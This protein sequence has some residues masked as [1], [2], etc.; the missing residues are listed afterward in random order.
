MLAGIK[1]F[2]QN[3]KVRTWL[4][5][6]FTLLFYYTRTRPP[7][8]IYDIQTVGN[9]GFLAVGKTGVVV[10][11]LKDPGNLIEV[12]SL[13]TFGDAYSLQV[14]GAFVFVADG[15][16]G[17][18]MLSTNKEGLELK[19][20]YRTPGDALD[21]AVSG[22]NA[23]AIDSKEDLL[24]LEV[25]EREGSFF[26]TSNHDVPDKAEKIKIL[27]N[28]AYISNNKNRF[29]IYDISVPNN[30]I[31]L[32]HIDLQA[33]IENFIVI[34][35]YAYLAA[36]DMGLVILDVSQGVEITIAGQYNQIKQAN[37][38]D[39]RGMYAYVAS[40]GEGY[41]VLDISNF[42]RITEVGRESSLSDAQLIR[43]VDDYACV[44]DD[45]IGLKS[46]Y[47]PVLFKFREQEFAKAQGLYE[48]V[49]VKGD[50]AYIAAGNSGLKVIEI[51][52][53]NTPLSGSYIDNTGDYATSLDSQGDYI[54][55]TY[56]QKGLHLYNIGEDPRSPT[57]EGV[58]S[59]VPGEPQD[60][61]VEGKLVFVASGS[62]GLQIIDLSDIAS[63][64]IYSLDTPG[65]AKGVFVLGD[66]AYIADG[67]NGLQI[68]A[69]T[70]PKNPSIIQNLNTF[71]DA[72]SVYVAKIKNSSE[73]ERTY[74][75]IANGNAGLF[76]A[77]ITD[78]NHPVNVATYT[79]Q[80]SAND[81]IVRD[82]TVYLLAEKNGLVLLDIS[83]IDNP[84]EL[85]N[86][87]TPGKAKRVD[88]GEDEI[89]YIAD[90]D[91][92]L[93]IISVFDPNEP[94]EIGFF[95]IPVTARV[96]LV[97]QNQGFMVDGQVGMWS[98][99]MTEPQA[100]SI[101][102]LF[103]TPGEARNLALDG[104][105]AY[106]AD[107][108]SGLQVV[109]VSNSLNPQLDGSYTKI[110]NA[111]AVAVRGGYA[112]V[113]TGERRHLHILDIENLSDIK[114]IGVFETAGE[115]LNIAIYESYAYIV[116]GTN[117][118]EVVNIQDPTDPSLTSI[119]KEFY[120]QDARSILFLYNHA[121]FVDGPGGMKVYSV[122]SPAKPEFVY[123]FPVLGGYATSITVAGEYVFLAVDRKGIFP[124]D[125]LDLNNIMYVGTLELNDQEEIQGDDEF[126]ALSI[127]VLSDPTQGSTQFINYTTSNELGLQIFRAEGNAF[128][129]QVGMYET[130]GE[131]SLGQVLGAMPRVVAGIM[132]GNPEVV[133][134][135]IWARLWYMAFGTGIFVGLFCLYLVLFSQFVLPVQTLREGAK[136]ITRLYSSLM[137][138]HGPVVFIKEG[139]I[140]A[141]PDELDRRGPGV[142]R[143]DLNSAIVL[144]KRALLQPQY[145]QRYNRYVRR[146][147]RAGQK[148]PRAR[149][150]GPGVHF[151]EPYENIHGIADLRPQFRIR[152]G[153][154]A[155][156]RDG[157]EIS[158]PV[159]ILFSLGQPPET[160]DV[161]YDGER[162]AE[163]LRVI[164]MGEKNIPLREK[165]QVLNEEE[166][167]YYQRYQTTRRFFQ[168][169]KEIFFKFTNVEVELNSENRNTINE[170]TYQAEKLAD[171]LLVMEVFEVRQFLGELK[172][173]CS[174]LNEISYQSVSEL[175]GEANHLADQKL[176]E[177][178]TDFYDNVYQLK[179]Q[180]GKFIMQLT[181][182]I[183]PDDR[184]EIHRYVQ[185]QAEIRYFENIITLVSNVDNN[186]TE[187]DDV[188]LLTHK[189]CQLA[190]RWGIHNRESIQ[191][192]TDCVSALVLEIDSFN[193]VE[194]Q[195][196]IYHIGMLANELAH[197][198]MN[199]F[200]D[201]LNREMVEH[202]QKSLRD[203]ESVSSLSEFARHSM[204]TLSDENPSDDD[205]RLF[206]LNALALHKSIRP[207]F[208]FNLEKLKSDPTNK[209]EIDIL[210][211]FVDQFDSTTSNLVRT[212][213][214]YADSY[215]TVADLRNC[216]SSINAIS[217]QIHLRDRRNFS[218]Y[219]KFRKIR[220]TV[221]DIQ[222]VIRSFVDLGE[223]EF[224][225]YVELIKIYDFVQYIRGCVSSTHQ[226]NDEK[227]GTN[228]EL[229]T[230]VVNIK[231]KT[232][233]LNQIGH[234]ALQRPVQRLNKW[235]GALNSKDPVYVYYY[236]KQVDELWE[237]L[238]AADQV[239]VRR[240][241]QTAKSNI[242]KIQQE[243][244]NFKNQSDNLETN[245]EV[246]YY[247]KSLDQIQ[248]I[249]KNCK[250]PERIP[251]LGGQGGKEI[252][253]G[254]FQFVRRRV[255]AA[256]YSQAL[257]VDQDGEYM[258][259]TNLPVHVAAQTFRDMVSKE[260][261]DYL[262]EPK[263]PYNYN[264]P[265]LKGNFSRTMRNQGVL[266]FRFIDHRDG[267]PLT[268]GS[269][270]A[271]E[272]LIYYQSREL[273]NPKVLRARGIKVIA[274]GFPDLF[275]VSPKI[276]EQWLETWRAPLESRAIDV[277]GKGKLQAVRVINQSRAQAQR[278]MAHTLARILQSSR[279]EEALAMRVFQA[280]ESTAMDQDTRQFLPRD[281]MYLLRSFKQWFI[282]G[283]SDDRSNSIDDLNSSED[284]Q[285]LE[286]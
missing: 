147:T 86:Q 229:R 38:V 190:I 111:I 192:F 108:S 222:M 279:S 123:S 156:T 92:G 127:A 266:A 9:Q 239:A 193:L 212:E 141:R 272:E 107:G 146:A 2:M 69:I 113:V 33:P 110:D 64:D 12:T 241:I 131:A 281:T 171:E 188:L 16:D 91:R 215:S 263:D 124:F 199:Y 182:E 189:I 148:I 97:R 75:F 119:G 233:M 55:V 197:E 26:L 246:R 280:L 180:R 58:E 284:Q 77:D 40:R 163:N 187:R 230:C 196:F 174:N 219:L 130:P 41:Y 173:L 101:L 228:P 213:Y 181:D 47:S 261:Y 78:L 262:Y 202:Y 256:I 15:P 178:M 23:F 62:E 36:E 218:D 37:D 87:P 183:N 175:V 80:G 176:G 112:Y 138:E 8:P 106:I 73:E 82:Q 100:P 250:Y 231:R 210:E 142:A 13:D 225:R 227:S 95:D 104:I 283:N 44:A 84:K 221:G 1:S 46:F 169:V 105:H 165:F 236:A 179:K 61:R 200:Y 66:N 237:Q 54:Y 137:G 208:E 191:R 140:I 51:E 257:D 255:L 56:R 48:D 220:Q 144:E 5:I 19:G 128:I 155:Y 223:P 89:A 49:I 99:D 18:K 109:N 162:N 34:G 260:Q 6:A 154:Q 81:V 282:P 116:E 35:S 217:Q 224:I 160:I 93:R 276:P 85:G 194:V 135:K 134:A 158:N 206:N 79:T 267:E 209:V 252:R 161:T 28:R 27:G 7:D 90:Y 68:V 248:D 76:I 251:N 57:S 265:K 103:P 149:V 216:F 70:D 98:L 168:I 157:I 24:V 258:S 118:I 207:E 25:N 115:A 247:N 277:R 249:L 59:S 11:D 172:N 195:W 226:N 94:E 29:M 17:L 245:G 43:I 88:L 63:P 122:E 253:V 139:H 132:T 39:V 117:G 184:E 96:L 3:P 114:E 170:I 67:E 151:I 150:E 254:P 120:L 177:I 71:G 285:L 278:D 275:P 271:D 102:S 201:Y 136:A 4:F 31:P 121:F 10:V 22:S 205:L 126:Q 53:L 129:Y 21:I 50:Y 240:Y 238:E 198:R 242:A 214:P 268:T 204:E 145:R 72:N 264:M 159:W 166:T 42:E 14:V 143:V 203:L 52:N 186:S 235:A 152:P 65:T 164:H 74:A 211:E 234:P 45:L 60:V 232:K 269:E 153:V 125:V 133:D 30:P 185:T 32:G 259:W 83:L 274:S 20:G 273:K 286:E 243:I 244:R 270:W 167:Q